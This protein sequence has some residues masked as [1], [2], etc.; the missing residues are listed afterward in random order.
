MI[1]EYNIGVAAAFH[2]HGLESVGQDCHQGRVAFLFAD[3]H[4]EHLSALRRQFYGAT[5]LVKAVDYN[6]ALRMFS[7]RLR[8]ALRGNGRVGGCALP[9]M[10][11]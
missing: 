8:D 10:G 11:R 9:E 6:S 3:A 1:R 7:T 2:V 4:A 5:L